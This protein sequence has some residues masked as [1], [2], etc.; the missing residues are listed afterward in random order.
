MHGKTEHWEK[1]F[2]SSNVQKANFPLCKEDVQISYFK[3]A[4]T[5][6]EI[7]RRKEHLH[8]FVCMPMRKFLMHNKMPILSHAI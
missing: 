1:L 2:G 5:Q 3:R 6:Q 4:A 7:Y 8:N